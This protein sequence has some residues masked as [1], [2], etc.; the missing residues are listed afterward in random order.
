MRVVS[1][2]L[3]CC[4]AAS[5]LNPSLDIGQYAH[6][7]WTIRDGFF[8]TGITTITQTPDG[9][10]WLGTEFG[11]LRF[12]GIRSI[13][14]L[15]PAGQRLPGAHVSRLITARDGT[16]WIGTTEGLASWKDGK[17]TPYKDL[18]GFEILALAED[19][20]GTVWAGAYAQSAGRLCAIRP[21][22]VQCYGQDGS[23]GLALT[24]IY[25]E[26]GSLW[27]GASTGLWRWKPGLPISYPIPGSA[28]QSI[29]GNDSGGLLI[30]TH[31]TLQ[32][33]VNSRLEPW[34]VPEA[35]PDFDP[36]KLFRDGA[37][38]LWIGSVHHGLALFDHG[39]TGL[40]ARTDGLSGDNISAVYEDRE[41]NIWIAT[42]GGLDRF[43]DF[44][45]PIISTTSGSVLSATDGSIWAGASSGLRRWK[46][47]QTTIYTMKDG[48]PD[49][50][51]ESL[52]ED[53][54]GR[55]WIATTLGVIVFEG[56]RFAAS[57]VP[58]GGFV[59]AMAED[60][61]GDLWFNQDQ[62]LLRLKGGREEE[63]IPWPRLGSD[64]TLWSLVPDRRR[65]GL[66]F[67]FVNRMAYFRDGEIRQS[68]TKADGLGSG[69][70]GDV[71]VDDDGTVWAATDGGLSRLKDGHITTL[72]SRNGLPC[73]SAHWTMEDDN[74]S[75]WLYMSC[76]LVRIPRA[77]LDAWIAN[78]AH[79]VRATAFDSSD[80]VRMIE[81][82][83]SGYSPRAAKAKDG[84]I[85]FVAGSE[86][87]VIDP[88]YLAFNKV[89]PP[90]HIE[91]ISADRKAY[92]M[93][94]NLRLPP[95]VRDLEIDYTALSLVAP[96]KNHFKYRLE[97]HDR[98][99]QDAGNRRQAFYND[100]APRNYRFRV[101]ASNNSGVW[102][103]AGA[104]FDFSIAPA[105]YQTRWFQALCVA[106]FLGLLWGLYRYRL[107]QIARQ[108]N[109]QLEARVGERTRIAR[110]L[111]D[112]LLQSFQG[113][114]LRLQVVS[115]LLT[116][117]KTE[118]A[119]E[120]LELS[121]QRA[122]QAIA[123]GRDTVRDL[124]LSATTTNEL[125]QALT[126]LGNELAAEGTA[127][128]RLVVEGPTLDLH[129]VVRDEV[130]R[131]VREALRN[132]FTH[133]KARHIEAEI[134][135]GARVFRVRIRDDGAG[136]AAAVLEAGRPGHYG[137]PGM[138]ERAGQIGAKLNIWSGDRAG[139][140]VELS[141][142]GSIA[143]GKSGKG[144]D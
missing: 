139:T 124:R 79:T 17:L 71:R 49:N 20:E 116:Q 62:G 59:H 93:S 13:S 138:R 98:D 65:G 111:H 117:G 36:R 56:G 70:V 76:G 66:W 39:R 92:E 64:G 118:R 144:A 137:L 10:L 25:E 142:A 103:E 127:A 108:F 87:Y 112:T 58:A 136:I 14:W 26:A 101:I 77:D 30:A 51:V 120:E 113:L 55:I 19:R 94:S 105:Y 110:D 34:S 27:V 89:A 119:Q 44:A 72:T 48:L 88:H 135:Y 114:M 74:Q 42:D 22:N 53:D 75:V 18:A 122:D 45:V 63:R 12:D 132:A 80:G 106:A 73:D 68:Y 4:G 3:A 21:G 125:A 143:Y 6:T 61:A 28:V 50:S 11:L 85:W 78:P 100:L 130:Y 1:V 91:Q 2:L 84:R 99:W 90:V 140:E 7:A 5:A 29:V 131:I 82:P 121:L 23:F 115:S 9:Y 32:Q 47:G 57:S 107:H 97:G 128:F 102:N 96:E 24:V 95:L 31:N 86:M 43:R 46:N 67:G 38:R 129:P 134:T 35:P 8:K 69:R 16:L 37:S 40:F 133:A 126:A 81:T 109:I 104:A 41:G 52:L 141:I 15:P 83:G 123:E 60:T 54:R 33:F